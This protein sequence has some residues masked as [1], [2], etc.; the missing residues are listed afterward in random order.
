MFDTAAESGIARSKAQFAAGGAPL[1]EPGLVFSRGRGMAQ[2]GELTV[3]I[4]THKFREVLA[5]ADDVSVLRRGRLVGSG[6]VSDLT[7]ETMAAMMIGDTVPTASSER[8]KDVP[9]EI[10]LEVTGLC[11]DDADEIGRAHV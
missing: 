5:Y 2:A 7:V 10:R 1:P 8:G 6:S 9:G 3:L 4:I 11:A